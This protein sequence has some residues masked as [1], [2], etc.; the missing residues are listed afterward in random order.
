MTELAAPTTELTA[1]LMTKLAAQRAATIAAHESAFLHR[2]PAGHLKAR[3]TTR[4]QGRMSITGHLLSL[5]QRFDRL[6]LRPPAASPDEAAL[7]ARQAATCAA[8]Q[9]WVW[10]GAG[11]GDADWWRPGARPRVRQRLALG[12]LRGADDAQAL[13]L[14]NAFAHQLDGSQRLVALG[15][16][17][18]GLGFRLQV[19]GHD[20]MW[21]RKRQAGDPW[22]A[23]WAVN[24][25]PALRHIKS[26]FRPRRATLILADRSEVQPLRLCLAALVARSDDFRHPVRWLWVGGDD[27]MAEQ[28]GLAMARFGAG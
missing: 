11:P 15:G 26:G 3:H 17:V 1:A 28:H 10:A 22:D 23:G 6:A 20:A 5:R 24:T 14:A 13:A 2:C 9:A 18:A 7:C 21:W 27:D 19:I 25:P 16:A 4:P 12:A 8:L